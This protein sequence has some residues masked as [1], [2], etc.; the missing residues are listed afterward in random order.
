MT[1]INAVAHREESGT[2]LFVTNSAQ[3]FC[4]IVHSRSSPTSAPRRHPLYM[5]PSFL[6]IPPLRSNHT[7]PTTPLLRWLSAFVTALRPT[8]P[9]RCGLQLNHGPFLSTQSHTL[10]KGAPRPLHDQKMF[11]HHR[12]TVQPLIT[13]ADNFHHTNP[14]SFPSSLSVQ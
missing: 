11:H 5:S 12:V 8:P 6:I 13:L 1:L 4:P 2:F 10:I 3:S 9:L 7:R 14:S